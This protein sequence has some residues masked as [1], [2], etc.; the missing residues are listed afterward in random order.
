MEIY[1]EVVRTWEVRTNARAFVRLAT[2]SGLAFG[3]FIWVPMQM[4][5]RDAGRRAQRHLEAQIAVKEAEKKAREAR[6]AA[7]D[8]AY[9]YAHP[10]AHRFFRRHPDIPHDTAIEQK[11]DSDP[12]LV[13]L[14]NESRLL[15]QKMIR[16]RS[17]HDPARGPTF[18]RLRALE[19]EIDNRCDEILGVGR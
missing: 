13:G 2:V 3:V 6:D 19:G 15:M 10:A 17:S 5:A 16:I 8:A 12:V 9:K 11:F 18:K 14:V 1:K 7:I 4:D